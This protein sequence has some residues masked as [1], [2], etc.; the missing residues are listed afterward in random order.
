[1]R[2][3]LGGIM[4]ESNTFN[5]KPTALEA[6]RVQRGDELV[7]WWRDTP[8]E[9]GGFIAGAKQLWVRVIPHLDGAGD[10][11]RNGDPR[12]FRAIDGGI[13]GASLSRAR[14]W[15]GCCSPCT[16]RW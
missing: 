13:A 8:H 2:I 4:H 12:S 3:A 9:V 1:M 14:S 5:H 11:G 16:A 7:R 6:F 15:T 10:P